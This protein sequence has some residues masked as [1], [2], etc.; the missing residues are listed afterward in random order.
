[1][2]SGAF[3]SYFPTQCDV[4]KLALLGIHEAPGSIARRWGTDISIR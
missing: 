4:F 2:P 1:M 3:G